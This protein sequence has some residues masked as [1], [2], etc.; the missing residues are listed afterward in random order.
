MDTAAASKAK[1]RGVVVDVDALE[2][3]LLVE[4]A[5]SLTGRARAD[6]VVDQS[7][8]GSTQAEIKHKQWATQLQQW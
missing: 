7:Q 2:G 4:E 5:P 1:K 6:P 8:R 3:N